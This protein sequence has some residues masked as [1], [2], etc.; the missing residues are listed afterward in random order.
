MG[1]VSR[2]T[3]WETG[4][5]PEQCLCRRDR[6]E[7]AAEGTL[8]QE[9]GLL[10][11][12]RWDSSCRAAVV[13]DKHETEPCSTRRWRAE[14]APIKAEHFYT[15]NTHRPRGCFAIVFPQPLPPTLGPVPKSTR[16]SWAPS[17]LTCDLCSTS[18]CLL[19]HVLLLHPQ[20]LISWA[21]QL[22]PAVS[23]LSSKPTD[24]AHPPAARSMALP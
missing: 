16:P 23:S 24:S 11:E 19:F 20:L 13:G 5:S 10:P 7:Q 17:S 9:S 4:L 6:A 12:G 18:C 2:T 21:T 8:G 3:S 14:W 15:V 22:P 1:H